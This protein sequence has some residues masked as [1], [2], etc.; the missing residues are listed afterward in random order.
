MSEEKIS[1]TEANVSTTKEN[2]LGNLEDN[3]E[4]PLA[5]TQRPF[6][7]KTNLPP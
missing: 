4:L 1:E 6:Q 7:N 2:N 3:G 5:S